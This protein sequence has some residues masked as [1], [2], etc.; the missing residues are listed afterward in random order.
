MCDNNFQNKESF[1]TIEEFKKYQLEQEI[2]RNLMRD[3]INNM[4]QAIFSDKNI[5]VDPT[6]FP[7]ATF[8]KQKSSPQS[9]VST[10]SSSSTKLFS[11][12]D[13]F[14]AHASTSSST[15]PPQVFKQD[16]SAVTTI[17]SFSKRPTENPNNNISKR[18]IN[19][20]FPFAIVLNYECTE[21]NGDDKTFCNM[22]LENEEKLRNHQRTKHG[23]QQF[24]CLHK[25]C[26]RSFHKR[27][28]N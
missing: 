25:K 26:T 1:I 16:T 27:Y 2:E 3:T 10:S 20:K 14:S 7:F 6:K 18:I 5:K 19:K 11:T 13:S 24:R 9:N 22:T 17:V 21:T 28:V 12:T 8:N 4:L 23:L 15:P